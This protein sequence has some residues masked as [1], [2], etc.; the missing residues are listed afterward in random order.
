MDTSLPNMPCLAVPPEDGA[1][2]SA[3]AE[4]DAKL[5][6]YSAA[7]REVRGQLAQSA[8]AEALPTT[9]DASDEAGKPTPTLL[10]VP[11][12][13]LKALTLETPAAPLD[14]RPASAGATPAEPQAAASTEEVLLASLDEATSKTVRVRR[15]LDPHKTIQEILKQIEAQKDH[16][17]PATKQASK[18]WFRRR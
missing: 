10:A 6:A 17:D 8:R 13:R 18:S 15:R 2:Q 4:L 1:L 14:G 5:V 12:A 11:L 3:L 9:A 16:A 7:V